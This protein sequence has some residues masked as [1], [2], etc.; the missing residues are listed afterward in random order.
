MSSEDLHAATRPKVQGTIN[1]AKYLPAQL[2]FF[3]MLSSISGAVGTQGQGNYAAANTFQDAFARRL[4]S[5][6]RHCIS[7]NLGVILN[8]G[9][10]AERDLVA[11]LHRDGFQGLAEGELMALLEYACD[12]QCP[13]ARDPERAQIVSGLLG[14]ETFPY[15]IFRACYWTNRPI[16]RY[17]MQLAD[18]QAQLSGLK[19]SAVDSSSPSAI[20]AAAADD[21]EAAEAA[22][23]LLV[24]RIAS[25]L[26]VP[27]ADID[28]RLP[29]AAFGIDSLISLELK[30]WIAR[31]LKANASVLDIMGAAGIEDLAGLVVG[32]TTLRSN[33]TSTEAQGDVGLVNITKRGAQVMV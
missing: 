32:K 3:V 9:Y 25:L 16:C 10:A 7:L 5:E 20:I 33:T 28:T 1:L 18:C 15:D 22:T 31:E 21:A 27:V 30:N 24:D 8:V 12:P 14:A 2:D 4:A 23:L 19:N 13:A 29:I 17:L 6:G 26:N 11:G